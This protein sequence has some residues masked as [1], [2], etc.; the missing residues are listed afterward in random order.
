MPIPT[1]NSEEDVGKCIRFLR[2][3]GKPLD[4][5][6]AICLEQLRKA[7]GGKEGQPKEK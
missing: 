5:C 4:Q 2:R 1:V 3:E 7:T 6:Q